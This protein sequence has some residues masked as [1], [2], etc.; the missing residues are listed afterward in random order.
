MP[1]VVISTS[2]TQGTTPAETVS[3]VTA[4]AARPTAVHWVGVRR[5]AQDH[6]AE[7]HREERIDIVAE[8]RVECPVIGDGP[9]IDAPVHRDEAGGDR[10]HDDHARGPQRRDEVARPPQRQ[11]HRP[12]DRHR[13]EHAMGDDLGR[14]D[15]GH[16]LHVE[17]QEPPEQVGRNGIGK[18]RGRVAVCGWG[19]S[20]P[21][22]IGIRRR[23]ASA[24]SRCA[25]S[26]G[27]MV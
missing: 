13:P 6:R 27:V 2:A 24:I 14:W 4:S 5:F 3:T 12:R 21:R 15:M 1:K 25:T 7:R 18:A 20:W 22:V 10:G 26:R 9:D 16:R 11:Q 8:R 19:P 17:R 23:P